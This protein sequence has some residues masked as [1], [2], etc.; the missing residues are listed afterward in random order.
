MTIAAV[1]TIDCYVMSVY[2]TI[3]DI[4]LTLHIKSSS[5]AVIAG[6]G[7]MEWYMTRIHGSGKVYKKYTI[8]N[9][10]NNHRSVH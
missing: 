9:I 10:I 1:T 6:C 7:L 5:V 8:N 4:S 3:L 2:H